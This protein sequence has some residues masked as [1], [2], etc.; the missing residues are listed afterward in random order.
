M[1]GGSLPT[2][3]E[4]FSRV[5]A[6]IGCAEAGPR[7]FTGTRDRLEG[8]R[9]LLSDARRRSVVCLESK[10]RQGNA[11]DLGRAVGHSQGSSLAR[12]RETIVGKT[13]MPYAIGVLVPISM[14]A[15]R[16]FPSYFISEFRAPPPRIA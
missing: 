1:R 8:W 5:A 11:A 15:L 14:A 10:R 13:D 3:L 16:G 4:D 6:S 12:V 7:L 9:G 2:I